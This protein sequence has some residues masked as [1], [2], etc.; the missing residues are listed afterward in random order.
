MSQTYQNETITTLFNE[1]EVKLIHH[2]IYGENDTDYSKITDHIVGFKAQS[3]MRAIA[4]VPIL[5]PQIYHKIQTLY[6]GGIY[7]M[8]NECLKEDLLETLI[9][10]HE[11]DN[12]QYND[13]IDMVDSD[14][15]KGIIPTNSQRVYNWLHEHG[16]LF[17]SNDDMVDAYQ[18]AFKNNNIEFAKWIYEHTSNK[19]KATTVFK[20]ACI[21]GAQNT[22]LDWIHGL[23]PNA[24]W[25]WY[26][27]MFRVAFMNQHKDVCIWFLALFPVFNFKTH[28]A[29]MFLDLCQTRATPSFA[30]GQWIIELL[31]KD[32]VDV[33]RSKIMNTLWNSACPHIQLLKWVYET[34][35]AD[36]QALFIQ[37]I[38]DDNMTNARQHV[39][40]IAIQITNNMDIF[41]WFMDTI[42]CH[43][44]VP[45]WCWIPEHGRFPCYEIMETLL[46]YIQGLHAAAQ[47]HDYPQSLFQCLMKIVL[48]DISIQSSSLYIHALKQSN[49][50]LASSSIETLFHAACLNGNLDMAQHIFSQYTC[51]KPI[52]AFHVQYTN[53]ILVW[54]ASVFT[55]TE[56]DYDALWDDSVKHNNIH[57]AT[58]INKQV[59]HRYVFEIVEGRLIVPLKRLNHDLFDLQTP[60]ITYMC[61]ICQEDENNVYVMTKCKHVFCYPCL[62]VWNEKSKTCPYCRD[63]V[64]CCYNVEPNIHKT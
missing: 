4:H 31:E 27:D 61:S 13:I 12:G 2:T 45:V 35:S 57:R 28:M 37:T 21:F 3:L 30:F 42:S 22:M 29:Q 11:L 15:R 56:Y 53:Q 49:T 48:H 6:V 5:V 18:T 59:Q 33:N 7:A 54:L 19:R 26:P 32:N 41:Q 51:T 9:V 1:A 47:Q 36:K 55:F 16:Y 17:G 40:S 14:L 10:I 58:W 20:D 8:L 46:T 50:I 24:E 39:A 44:S 60:D 43:L 25:W 63:D 23:V 62:K 34:S 52:I 38:D 64:L